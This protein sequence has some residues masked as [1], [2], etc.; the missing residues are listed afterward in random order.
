MKLLSEQC[1]QQLRDLLGSPRTSAEL[2]VRHVV[3]L[4]A[5]SLEELAQVHGQPSQALGPTTRDMSS[6]YAQ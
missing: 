4:P 6:C 1:V 5:L 3:Q 2:Q